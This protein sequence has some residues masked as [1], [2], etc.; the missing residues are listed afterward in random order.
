MNNPYSVLGVLQSDSEETIKKAYRTKAFEIESSNLP[1]DE[2]QAK[3]AELDSAFDYIF[4]EKRGTGNT[5]TSS[6][7]SSS[8]YSEYT[9]QF[10]D[11]R[12]QIAEGRLNDAETILDGIP[13]NMCSAE[14][15]YLKGLIY[16]SRGW[17]NEAHDYFE[18]AVSMDS[19]NKEYREAFDSLSKKANGGYKLDNSDRTG[20]SDC[21]AGCCDCDCCGCSDGCLDDLCTLWCCDKVC[22]CFGCDLCECC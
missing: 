8:S 3:M 9:S 1:K 4:N 19:S 22:E 15:Y 12:R 17:L 21:F 2:K 6:F 5:G 20:C 10:P 18:T 13:Q 16:R 11:V 14:W 7:Q